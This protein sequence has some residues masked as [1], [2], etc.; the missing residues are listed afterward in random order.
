MSDM[1]IEKSRIQPIAE[2][3]PKAGGKADVQAAM[4]LP[5]QSPFPLESSVAECVAVKKLRFAE[6]KYDDR[7]LAVSLEQFLFYHIGQFNA[8]ALWTA[9]RSRG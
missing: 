7:V 1:R 3:A 2:S 6:D 9:I 8:C 4:L 5:A